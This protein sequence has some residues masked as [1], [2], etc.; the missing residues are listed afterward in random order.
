MEIDDDA[1]HLIAEAHALVDAAGH[2]SD[3]E[4]YDQL[5]AWARE[6]TAWLVAAEIPEGFWLECVLAEHKRTC[7]TD[8]AFNRRFVAI[9]RKAVETGSIPAKFRLACELDENGTREEAGCLFAEAAEAGHAHA[10][11]CHGLDLLLGGSGFDKDP[12]RGLALIQKSA[13]LKF[14]GAIQFVSDAYATGT[15]GYPRDEAE[16][17]RWKKKLGDKDVITY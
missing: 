6:N 16:S 10:M 15:H 11:W 9:L 17:A 4:R 3:D 12:V 2:A 13:E 5:M 7:F 1:Q 14:E 8:D